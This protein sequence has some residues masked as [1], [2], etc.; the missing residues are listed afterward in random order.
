MLHNY[1]AQSTNKSNKNFPPPFVVLVC[2]QTL[3]RLSREHG[4]VVRVVAG[5]ADDFCVLLAREDESAI[6]VSADGD[7]LIYA[8]ETGNFAALQTFPFEWDNTITFP[9]YSKLREGLGIAHAN[10]MVELAALLRE[11]ES[12]SVAQCI[13]CV[14]RNQTLD[15]ISCETLHEY[16]TIY[17]AT[18]EFSPSTEIQEMLDC[19][20]VSGR[21]T[22]LFFP[23]E[24]PTMWLPLLP[25]SNPPRRTA[26]GISHSIRQSAYRELQ[27]R[28]FIHSDHVVE[29]VHCGKRVAEERVSLDDAGS[30]S[31]LSESEQLF[32][33]AMN[34][35]LENVSEAEKKY[36]PT[37]ARMFC[38][39]Q[40]PSPQLQHTIVPAA[41]QYIT[42]QY[43]AFIYSFIMLLQAQF[44]SST[45][46]PEF[47]TLWDL[48]HFKTALSTNIE[49]AKSLW[50]KITET[51]SPNIQN[52][53]DISLSSPLPPKQRRKKSKSPNVAS[54]A[55][56]EQWNRFSSLA[57]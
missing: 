46:I 18:K 6:I 47:A 21:L 35:L 32:I 48:P 13:A 29:I 36:L 43:Q 45:G 34:I 51:K 41:L 22:E 40:Q 20:V 37:F 55:R 42:L 50:L 31:I 10:G 19:G 4:F 25:I 26:W 30:M 38:L 56:I 1:I 17:M 2:Q 52:L 14:N 54:Q 57:M 49:E 7:F 23:D 15:H 33:A 11:D 39:L 27:K 5:E 9:V 8:S 44:P 24:K 3:L 16:L 28:G 53:C 12:L